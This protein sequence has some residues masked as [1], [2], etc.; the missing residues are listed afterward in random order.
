MPGR[1]LDKHILDHT[2]LTHMNFQ[3]RRTLEALSSGRFW[4][5]GFHL[6]PAQRTG[7][8]IVASESC[9][10]WQTGHPSPATGPGSPGPQSCPSRATAATTGSSPWHYS[11]VTLV[12]KLS[13]PGFATFH[14]LWWSIRRS[15][16]WW[17]HDI[18]SSSGLR[19]CRQGCTGRF[20]LRFPRGRSRWLAQP[21]LRYGRGWLKTRRNALGHWFL[22]EFWRYDLL[23]LGRSYRLRLGGRHRL[24]LLHSLRRHRILAQ[25]EE[26]VLP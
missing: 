14:G 16:R 22:Y 13:G 10:R 8:A 11:E 2:S 25:G 18:A 19:S 20:C 17:S 3:K 7:E 26:S 12:K 24:W 4:V 23:Q 15:L 5:T 6:I 9:A 1:A 21:R